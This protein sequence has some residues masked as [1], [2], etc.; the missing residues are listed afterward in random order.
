[1]ALRKSTPR[2]S[3]S[4]GVTLKTMSRV[5][6]ISNM[7]V[8][9]QIRWICVALLIGSV[10]AASSAPATAADDDIYL[11]QLARYGIEPTAESITAY[12]QSLTPS[13]EQQQL[14]QRLISQLG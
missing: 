6:R 13:S 3:K 8:P 5:F 12:L 9:R 4:N 14:L 2:V 7:F 1:M 10:V 11:E